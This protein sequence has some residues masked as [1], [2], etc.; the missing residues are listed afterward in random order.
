MDARIER[1]GTTVNTWIVGDDDEVIVVD[2][3]RDAAP[4][5]AAVGDRE[6]MAVICTHGHAGHVAAAVEVA[7]RDEA[8]VAVHPRDRVFWR[9]AHPDADPEIE[10]EEGGIFEVAGVA[11][12]VIHAPG[13]SPGS[14]CLYS[15]DLQ[16]VFVGDVLSAD[17][18]V[19]HESEF[20]DFSRQ[21][22]SIGEQVLTLPGP[23]RVLPGHGDELTVATAEKRFDSWVTAGP[24]I[25]GGD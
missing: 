1:T 5:L 3:G 4:V 22:S 15:D 20:P 13:H 7:A 14:V 17:G 16:A 10:M 21:L 2:P 8:P 24:V 12:E 25:G 19:P 9:E 6:V 11:L 23:T 18:P